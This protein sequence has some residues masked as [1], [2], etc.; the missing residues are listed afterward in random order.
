M[1]PG[2]VEST[3]VGGQIGGTKAAQ[4]PFHTLVSEL[5]RLLG[6]SSGLDS[7]DVDVQELHTLMERYISNMKDCKFIKVNTLGS[8]FHDG[9]LPILEIY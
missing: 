6:P 1:A 3:S 7:T 5:S 4:D 9:G 8:S 2:L